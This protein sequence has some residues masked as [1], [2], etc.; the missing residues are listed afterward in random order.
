MSLGN[1][2]QHLKNIYLTIYI[3][4][5]LY[6]Y[7]MIVLCIDQAKLWDTHMTGKPTELVVSLKV[8]PNRICKC[9]SKL[10]HNFSH[11]C[12]WASFSLFRIK[13]R[14]LSNLLF[15]V[16]VLMHSIRTASSSFQWN[17]Y[18]QLP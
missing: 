18:L 15:P 6:H 8:F 4:K 16:N 2:A 12:K 7:F 14:I 1:K 13:G 3:I 9:I 10:N 5:C 11:Q 17:L